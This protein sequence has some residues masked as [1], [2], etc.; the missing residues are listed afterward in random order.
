MKRRLLLSGF[1]SLFFLILGGAFS[2]DSQNSWPSRGGMLQNIY[3]LE[4]LV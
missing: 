3:F 1:I 4:G 2:C